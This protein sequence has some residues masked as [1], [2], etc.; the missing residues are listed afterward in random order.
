MQPV[1]PTVFM[2]RY[3]LCYCHSCM[4]VCIRENSWVA[5]LAAAKMKV[6]KVAIVFGNTIH[7][8]NTS[9]QEFLQDREWV[10]HE[11]KHI[12]QYRRNG[13]MGFLLRYLGES[14]RKGYYNNR[15]EKE[16]R[17]SEKD[18]SLLSGVQFT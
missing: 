2:Q 7:L 12:Q 18:D 6:E 13:F 9:R 16:A 4:K 15:F 1:S 11:L 17:N 3:G 8:C 5:K 10:C 14:I